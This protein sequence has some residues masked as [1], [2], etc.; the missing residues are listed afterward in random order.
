MGNFS[1]ICPFCKK[2][3]RALYFYGPGGKDSLFE[4]C[5]LFFIY[6][7]VIVEKMTGR[8]NGYGTVF[9]AGGTHTLLAEPIEETKESDKDNHFIWEFADWQT[10]V[11]LHFK[12]DDD[13]DKN[14]HHTGFAICHEV[15]NPGGWIPSE[16][17]ED[18]PNQGWGECEDE[19]GW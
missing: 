11:D 10:L 2:G 18:D 4:R 13:P 3:V 17:G 5:T 16:R 8:Y 12:G 15:C 6:K 7:G 19:D 14:D 9:K 1:Y